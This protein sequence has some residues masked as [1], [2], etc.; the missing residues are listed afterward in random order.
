MAKEEIVGAFGSF[1]MGTAKEAIFAVLG[2]GIS[3]YSFMIFNL[4]CAP[5][6]AAMG[7]IRR[8]MNSPKWTAAA[9]GYMCAFA[10]AISLIVYQLGMF[11]SGAGFTVWTAVAL[12]VL[13]T[14]LYFIF[15]RNKYLD[16]SL[17][18]KV[19]SLKK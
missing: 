14:L 4:L 18:V 15:R 11:I 19:I 2:N 16:N 7:A 12:A 17:K 1:D 6:F 13:V 9:I 10:Y 8:E 5:C 3:A